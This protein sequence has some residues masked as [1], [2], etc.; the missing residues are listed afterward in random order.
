MRMMAFIRGL[1]G[2]NC[3]PPGPGGEGVWGTTGPAEG[4][5][6]KDRPG[7]LRSPRELIRPAGRADGRKNLDP[8][9]GDI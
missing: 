7:Y 4:A 1:E 6:K 3:A 8:S 9:A 5:K 2:F